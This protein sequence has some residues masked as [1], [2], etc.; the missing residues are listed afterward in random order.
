[1]TS[2]FYTINALSN[3]QAVGRSLVKL[4]CVNALGKSDLTDMN[5]LSVEVQQLAGHNHTFYGS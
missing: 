4:Y 2:S 1:M 5:V 3:Q